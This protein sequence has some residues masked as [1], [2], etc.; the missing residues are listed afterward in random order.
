MPWYIHKIKSQ[1]SNAKNSNNIQIKLITRKQFHA[2]KAQVKQCSTNKRRH[3][4]NI[5]YDYFFKEIYIC[6]LALT[7]DCCIC[8]FFYILSCASPFS[9]RSDSSMYRRR[10]DI[11]SYFCLNNFASNFTVK[12]NVFYATRILLVE[13]SNLSKKL[14]LTFLYFFCENKVVIFPI[15]W[16]SALCYV[17]SIEMSVKCPLI[18]IWCAVECSNNLTIFMHQ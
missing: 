4:N 5:N 9:I 10:N 13:C 17:I 7:F 18:I 12:E 2:A 11:F 15:A 3:T 8:R 14:T 1:S 6:A 16:T